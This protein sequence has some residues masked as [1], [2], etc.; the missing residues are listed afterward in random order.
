[1]KIRYQESQ[2]FYLILFILIPSALF[3]LVATLLQW[4]SNAMPLGVGIPLAG[5][6]GLLCFPF[7]KMVITVTDQVATVKFGTGIFKKSI[8][9]G[10]LDLI[11]ARTVSLPWYW[12]VGYRFTPQ[13]TLFST[14]TGK[15]L[16]INTKDG[17]TAFFV[18]TSNSIAIIAAIKE[19][20]ATSN[21]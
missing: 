13:G 11:S 16:Y 1:M 5:V 15:G 21:I 9:I 6:L 7:Y 19:A 18:S 3:I 2:P 14:T 8:T 12:G 17:S 4:G 20:Q 10:D